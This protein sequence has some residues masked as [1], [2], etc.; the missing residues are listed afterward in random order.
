VSVGL[1]TTSPG[2]AAV[3]DDVRQPD[4]DQREQEERVGLEL[5]ERRG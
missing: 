4:G 5:K 1:R 2:Q 3:A